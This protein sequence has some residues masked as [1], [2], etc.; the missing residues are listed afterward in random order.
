MTMTGMDPLLVGRRQANR[1]NKRRFEGKEKMHSKKLLFKQKR[2]RKKNPNLK[3]FVNN[4]EEIDN[5]KKEE[6][7]ERNEIKEEN[8]KNNNFKKENN[9][10]NFLKSFIEEKNDYL[11]ID[12]KEEKKDKN[13]N[14]NINN[15]N[16]YIF[17]MEKDIL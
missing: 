2:G 8:N 1:W 7:V 5:E 15:F 3:A 13:K 14:N 4:K 12:E 11:K 9:D 6:K 10:N 17:E 16:L